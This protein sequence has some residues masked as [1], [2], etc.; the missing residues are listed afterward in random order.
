MY[1]KIQSMQGGLE[2]LIR[3]VPGF[4]GY[5]EKEDRREADK[6][7]REQIVRAFEAQENQLNQYEKRLV[8]AGGLAYME[9][10]QS[11]NSKMRTFIDRVETAPRGYAGLFDAIKVKEAELAR[12]YAF[13][14]ALLDF[15]GRFAEAIEAFGAAVDAS[16]GIE[17][18]I[19]TLDELMA[20][21]NE[22]FKQR[23][24]VLTVLAV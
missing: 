14:N 10:V 13:D 9:K 6:L 18:A 17:G 12:L 21:A 24:D 2:D 11:V 5:L 7:L 4:K 15:E 1:D 19:R 20:E 8:D 23:V 3:K 16:E 22:T